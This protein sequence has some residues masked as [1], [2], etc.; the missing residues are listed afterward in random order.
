MFFLVEGVVLDILTMGESSFNQL[1]I[2]GA[3]SGAAVR[4]AEKKEIQKRKD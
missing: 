3:R 2:R 4:V 1:V